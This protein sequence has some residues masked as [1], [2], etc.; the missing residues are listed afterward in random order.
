M[1]ALSITEIL[2]CTLSLFLLVSAVVVSATDQ[3][4]FVGEEGEFPPSTLSSGY[5]LGAYL[6]P[7]L[8]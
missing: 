1:F 7:E 3:H 4:P 5:T 2:T 8:P 6:G